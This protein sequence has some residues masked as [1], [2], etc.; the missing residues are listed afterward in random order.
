MTT[1]REALKTTAFTLAAMTLPSAGFGQSAPTPPPA[2]DN[3]GP[4]QL[5]PLPY[6][7]NALEPLIDAQTMTIH[8]GKHHAA[9]VNN[10]NKALAGKEAL[11][12]KSVEEL[13]RSLSS[14]P[15]EIRTAVRNNGGG[16][17]NHSLFWQ[18]LAP[19]APVGPK[20]DLA[21]AIDKSFDSFT[22]FQEKFTEAATKVFGSGWAWL[23]LTPKKMLIV[24]ATPNQDNPLM[25]G[26][27][28]LFGI[29]VWEHAYYLKYQNR[30]ADYILAFQKLVNWDFLGERYA[31]LLK[32]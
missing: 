16:H 4:F 5:P 14:V 29:D 28:P 30:R 21:Q 31:T 8:H 11:A 23:S 22:L 18:T 25:N 3:T 15:E 24:E 32:S 10:L 2:A 9:Y 19:K 7:E 27:T 12:K 1:R 13:C 6:A 17:Y 26:N 20:G